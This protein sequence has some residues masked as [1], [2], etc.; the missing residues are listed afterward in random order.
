MPVKTFLLQTIVS[1]VLTSFGILLI[2]SLPYLFFNMKGQIAV[3]KLI[4]EKKLNNTVGLYDSLVLNYKEYFLHIAHTVESIFS[5][6]FIEYYAR[7]SEHTLFPEFFGIYLHSML[8]LTV[9][10]II[11][12]FTAVMLTVFTMYLSPGKRRIPKAIIFLVESLPDIF[13]ILLIQLLIIWIYKKTEILL[14]NITS[15]FDEEAIVLPIMVLAIL[16]AVYIHKHLLLSF[17]EE[18]KRPYV[19]LALGKG[20]KRTTILVKH[21]LRN[22]IITLFNHFK[23]IFWFALANL[24]MLEIIFDMPGFM[25]FIYENGVVNPELLTYGLFMV[26]IPF[27]IFF[28]TGKWILDSLFD[29]GGGY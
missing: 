27:F 19:E 4:D 17:E 21:I 9:A 22:S 15:G 7:G 26:F 18:E 14:L 1:F 25:T 24:L 23:S 3:L 29:I 12:L 13:I 5:G 8:Y 2:G 28:T 16:P 20:L 11:G 10:L 6:G